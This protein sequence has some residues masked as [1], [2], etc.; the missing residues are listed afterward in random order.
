MKKFE[1]AYY[2]TT[3]MTTFLREKNINTMQL[4]D[5]DNYNYNIVGWVALILSS[6]IKQPVWS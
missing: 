6:N 2:D 4:I 5:I 1:L 3:F